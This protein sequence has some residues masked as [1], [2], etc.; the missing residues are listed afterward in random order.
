MKQDPGEPRIVVAETGAVPAIAADT[1]VRGLAGA[2][3]A[4]GLAHWVTTG[5]STPADVYRALLR[6]ERRDEVAWGSVHLW[7]GDDRYVPRDHPLSNVRAVDEILLRDATLAVAEGDGG[8]AG[9]PIPI[10]QTHPFRTAESIGS[11]GDAD[12]C[13]A[14][15]ADELAEHGPS[16]PGGWPIFD[17]VFLGI[18]GDGHLL[19]VFPGSAAFDADAWALA[20]PAPTHIEPH[21]ERVT[22]HPAI[23][24]A[25]RDVLVVVTGAA[26]A[27]VLAEILGPVREPRRWPAQVARHERATWVLDEAAAG[28]L[29]R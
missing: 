6:P 3:D 15:L 12:S 23:V 13:A 1:I 26:K 11:G 14:A 22:M 7:W 27:D 24:T 4:R 28:R 19:S 25:A 29:V 18:G 20:I 9:L 10:E 16:S 8:G 2:I 5:G 17:L 21:V